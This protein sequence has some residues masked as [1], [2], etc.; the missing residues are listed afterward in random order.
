MVRI[1]RNIWRPDT[2]GCEFVR[3]TDK[4]VQPLVFEVIWVF[5]KCPVHQNVLD[6]DLNDVIQFEND[7]ASLRRISIHEQIRLV[8]FGSQL[9]ASPESGENLLSWA[10]SGQD[11]NRVCTV[12][13]RSGTLSIAQKQSLQTLADMEFGS[14]KVVIN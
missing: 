1:V 11:Y 8:G 7:M 9:D 6:A 2:C 10:F 4:D 13:I 3:R 12:S 5:V 14:G